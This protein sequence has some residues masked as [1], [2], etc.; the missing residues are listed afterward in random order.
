MIILYCDGSFHQGWNRGPIQYKDSLLYFRGSLNTKSHLKYLVDNHGLADANKVLFTGASAGGI[1]T[2][3]WSNYV[4]T[5]VKNPAA[6]YSVADSGVFMNLTSAQ[7]GKYII[8]AQ[9]RNLFKLSNV[10]ATTPLDV[11][12]KIYHR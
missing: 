6:V 9:V 7:T 2:Y 12:N 4:R 1:A 3:I 11:C 5:L 8:D 10:D